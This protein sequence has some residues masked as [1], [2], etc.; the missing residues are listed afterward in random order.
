MALEFPSNPNEGQIYD[1]GTRRWQWDGAAWVSLPPSLPLNELFHW[2][3]SAALLDPNAL[4]LIKGG[5]EEETGV[6][7]AGETWL[8]IGAWRVK[9]AGATNHQF[10]RQVFPNSNPLVLPEGTAYDASYNAGPGTVGCLVF[11]R[12]NAALFAGNAGYETDPKGLYYS[13]LAQATAGTVT[14]LTVAITDNSEQTV[15]IPFAAATGYYVTSSSFQDCAW[16]GFYDGVQTSLTL[17]PER[18]DADPFRFASP[19]LLA[20]NTDIYPAF[21]ARGANSVNG[22]AGCTLVEIT[23]DS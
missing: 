8:V 4:N 14:S 6:V 22:V 9:F 17:L 18:S 20:L 7:P 13:R 5:T 1:S 10:I 11:Y 19:H 21:S 23:L 3:C 16:M 2:Q 12:V 15:S